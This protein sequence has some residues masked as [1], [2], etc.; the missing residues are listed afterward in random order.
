MKNVKNGHKT[1]IVCL[2]AGHCAKENRSPVVPEFYES[3]FNWKLHD[4]LAQKLKAYGIKVIK[5]R[6]GINSAMELTIRGKQAKGCDLFLSIH[7]NAA[8]NTNANYVLGVHMVDDDCGAIDE[9]S[10]QV[11]KL[12]SDCVAEI[13]G[14]KAEAWTKKSSSDRDGNGY[15]DDYYGVLRGAHSVGTAAV[16]LEHGFYTN[17]AQAQFLLMDANLEKLAEAEAKAIAEWFG[18]DKKKQES[19]V[20]GNPYKLELVSIRRSSRGKQVEALQTLL[21]GKGFSCGETGVDG[22]FGS[23]TEAALKLYQVSES[24]EPDGIAGPNTMA[25]LLGY[26]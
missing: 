18:V 2:D 12:L 21:I 5:T 24:L 10:K 11:A 1:P 4:L 7:A 23:Q 14:V 15:K 3:E 6:T 9:Q 8:G 26:R 16:I 19:A 20:V 22:S 17:K 13:M 25:A